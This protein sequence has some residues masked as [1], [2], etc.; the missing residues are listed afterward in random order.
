MTTYR[1]PITEDNASLHHLGFTLRIQAVKA[2]K[3][4]SMTRFAK[5]YEI[6]INNQVVHLP[7]R[8]ILYRYPSVEFWAMGDVTSIRRIEFKVCLN[9]WADF[10]LFLSMKGSF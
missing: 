3:T 4:A 5:K 1:A 7:S 6:N 10:R 9:L 2:S 8:R